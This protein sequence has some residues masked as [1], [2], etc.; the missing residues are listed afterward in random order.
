MC[1]Y[2]LNVSRKRG[3]GKLKTKLK[4]KGETVILVWENHN[5]VAKLTPVHT[6]LF[7]GSEE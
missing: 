6:K 7:S 4:H 5:F 2:S 3:F 1:F